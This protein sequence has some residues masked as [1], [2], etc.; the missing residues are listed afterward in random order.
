MEKTL[1]QQA[2]QRL[3][4]EETRPSPQVKGV[5]P[6]AALGGAQAGIDY[7]K[8]A[9]ADQTV[10]ILMLELLCYL[11]LAFLPLDQMI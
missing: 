7:Q 2:E 10:S 8:I 9:P 1:E 6:T 4:M 5:D 3:T 11:I